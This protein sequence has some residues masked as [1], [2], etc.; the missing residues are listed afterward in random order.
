MG[1][2]GGSRVAPAGSGAVATSL[3]C[4]EKFAGHVSTF[5]GPVP[6]PVSTPEL[7]AG[8]PP[9]SPPP[10][11]V[12]K[13]RCVDGDCTLSLAR[14]PFLVEGSTV[15]PID[16]RFALGDDDDGCESTRSPLGSLMA[17][18][19]FTACSTS[20]LERVSIATHASKLKPTMDWSTAT[21]SGSPASPIAPPRLAM[22]IWEVPKNKQP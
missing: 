15:E 10:R 2:L 8:P 22:A 1:R 16:R 14:R 5:C 17:K 6:V 20:P 19:R 4:D 7:E 13:L 18:C 12:F 11:K 9:T 3:G 21:G